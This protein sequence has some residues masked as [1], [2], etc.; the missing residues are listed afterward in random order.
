M[1]SPVRAV[2]HDRY[3]PPEV[4]RIE[5][6]DPP[7][8]AEIEVLVRVMATTVTRTDCAIRSAK[9]F[10]WRFFNGL[11]R[12]RRKI[13]GM[14]LSGV[15]EAVG[16][17]TT[18]F[19][20]GD[21][22][23]GIIDFGAHAELVTVP[24]N[25]PLVHKPADLGFAEAAAVCDGALQALAIFRRIHLVEGQRILVYG[26]SG[27]LGSAAVQLGRHFGAEVTAVCGAENLD[28]MISLG[29][30]HVIDYT[31]EDFTEREERY[32]VVLD[33]VDKE[34]F[35]R[36]RRSV[37]RGGVYVATD[38]GTLWQNPFWSLATRWVGDR[39]LV[40]TVPR[41][42]KDD[43]L[44]LRGLLDAGEYRAVIDRTY[45]LEMA[46]EATRYV[47]SG[48]KTGNVVLTVAN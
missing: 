48:Q 17:A 41:L 46:V 31:K 11:L 42:N 35:L 40:M 29:A 45:P 33:A 43:V 8:P 13:L 5:T 39:T 4:L 27:S 19:K 2:V 7:S 28:L 30:D 15:V 1:L 16:S 23:F 25:G 37:K 22:I 3:G 9:P 44:F 32:D 34:S 6:V 10:V 21:E 36:C 12:P 47:E 14:E 38:V 24:E 18:E 20:P 26:S